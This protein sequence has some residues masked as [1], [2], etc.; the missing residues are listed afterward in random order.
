MANIISVCWAYPLRAGCDVSPP[1]SGGGISLL[2]ASL[3]MHKMCWQMLW[4]FEGVILSTI[5]ITTH[6][7][8]W[9]C[10]CCNMLECTFDSVLFH[11][12]LACT[13][14]FG[15]QLVLFCSTALVSGWCRALPSCFMRVTWLILTVFCAFLA[16][17]WYFGLKLSAPKEPCLFRISFEQTLVAKHLAAEIVK[18]G[19][20]RI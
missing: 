5:A 15:W 14:F 20:S 3:R 10:A 2:L 8:V 16:D 18:G 6:E 4:G 12:L 7:I 1:F 11:V 19:L 17:I 9:A 13:S